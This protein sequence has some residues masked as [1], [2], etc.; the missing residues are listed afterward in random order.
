MISTYKLCHFVHEVIY[1]ITYRN[2]NKSSFSK[3]RLRQQTLFEI[4]RI[5]NNA[6]FWF[7]IVDLFV[8]NNKSKFILHEVTTWSFLIFSVI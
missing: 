8:L 2:Q 3:P 5:L 7:R 6:G 1:R 4:N